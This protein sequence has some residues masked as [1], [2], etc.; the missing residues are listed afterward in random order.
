VEQAVTHFGRLDALVNNASN[1]FPTPLGQ[2]TAEAMDE[3][4]AVNARAPLLLVD[5]QIAAEQQKVLVHLVVAWPQA[6]PVGRKQDQGP[7][8]IACQGLERGQAHR[9]RGIGHGHVLPEE[10]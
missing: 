9:A 6:L 2:V 10:V 4:Y 8:M 3:L 5:G 7:E 1:F